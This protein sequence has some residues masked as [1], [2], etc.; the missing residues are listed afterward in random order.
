MAKLLYIEASPR[1]KRSASIEVSMA[2]LEAYRAAHPGDEIQTLDVWALDLPRFDSD[3]MEAK[4][5]GLSGATLTGAQKAAWE[6]VRRLAAPF[7]AAD[8]LLF[9]VPMWN[10][11]IPY[12]LTH[13]I[14]V[15]SQKDVLFSFDAGGFAGLLKARK[16]AVIYARG[17]DYFSGASITPAT[18]YDFQRPYMEMWLRFIG[19]TEISEVV[20]EKTLFGAEIDTAGRAAAKREAATLA[21]RF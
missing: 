16:A 4:Y 11:G 3:A 1:K 17:L 2:F 21:Q 12:P 5:A 18:G 15:I 7:L 6:G 20:I 13:L 10:F 8:K 19:V 9:G 14:D